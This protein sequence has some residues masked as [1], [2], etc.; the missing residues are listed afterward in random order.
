[1]QPMR[2]LARAVELPLLK[3]RVDDVDE[4]LV[5]GEHGKAVSLEST[6]ACDLSSAVPIRVGNVDEAKH[7]SLPQ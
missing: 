4:R 6:Q 3:V 5:F 7:G 1:M 2:R